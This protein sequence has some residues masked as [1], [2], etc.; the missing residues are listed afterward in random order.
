MEYLRTTTPRPY[1][2]R[3]PFTFRI[4]LRN[5]PNRTALGVR[6]FYAEGDEKNCSLDL[7]AWHRIVEG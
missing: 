4:A 6:H 5:S 2:L 1:K 7:E 3:M